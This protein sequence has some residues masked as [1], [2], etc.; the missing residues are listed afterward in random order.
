M[1]MLMRMRGHARAPPY[2]RSRD[3]IS[4]RPDDPP[5]ILVPRM[6]LRSCRRFVVDLVPYW[7][8][9]ELETCMVPPPS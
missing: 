6:M 3:L 2:N 5:V 9:G 7:K 4:D 8:T 1:R